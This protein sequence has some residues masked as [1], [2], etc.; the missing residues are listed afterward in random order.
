[1]S[2]TPEALWNDPVA[3]RL[4]PTAVLCQGISHGR[5]LDRIDL[6][7]PI[8]WRVLIVSRPDAAA[9][10]LLRVIG[11]LARPRSGSVRLAGL[12]PTATQRAG[13]LV[14]YVG[15]QAGLYGWMTPR[16]ALAL[17]A[18]LVALPSERIDPLLGRYGLLPTA[19]RPMRRGGAA[20]RQR[21][22][23]AAAVLTDPEVLLLDDALSAVDLLDR[24][25][26]LTADETRRTV[27]LASRYPARE[28]G[29]CDHVALIRDGRVALL[30]P[31]ADLAAEGLPLSM[32]GIEALADRRDRAPVA[33]AG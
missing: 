11:G 3:R 7:V 25:A 14:S 8:G 1:M 33:R 19:D 24:A 31:I 6:A 12:D 26:L 9:S 29:I 4:R 30:A 28:A 5:Q 17:S 27:L 21:V 13:G 23:F 10:D 18:R 15:P 20:E 32:H 16:E 22:A 2:S